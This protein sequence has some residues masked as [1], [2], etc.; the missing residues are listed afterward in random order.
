MQI[1][2][3]EEKQSAVL[4]KISH[5]LVAPGVKIR[6]WTSLLG[7]FNFCCQALRHG[8]FHLTVF[9]KFK[10]EALLVTH[11]RWEAFVPLPS[12]VEQNLK[13]GSCTFPGLRRLFG[14]IPF[15]GRS[16]PMPMTSS[17]GLGA[18]YDGYSTH[19]L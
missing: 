5:L 19:G 14:E 16:I 3:P 6:Q 7:S 18:T 8:R 12:S 15:N 9:E 1:E 10:C 4:S 13:S 17:T 11:D 2:L